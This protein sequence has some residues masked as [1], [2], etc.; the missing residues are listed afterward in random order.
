LR[1][2]KRHWDNLDADKLNAVPGGVNVEEAFTAEE[3]T[4]RLRTEIAFLSALHR[5]ITL[6]FYYE[7]K[8]GAEIAG[9]LNIT[10]STVRWHLSEIKKKLKEGIEMKNLNYEPKKLMVGHDG[11]PGEMNMCGLGKDRLADNIILTCYGKALTVEEIARTLTVAA[12]Y[13]EHHIKDLV[14][15]DYLRV[16]DKNKY[17]TTFFISTQRHHMLA[18]KYKYH[19]IG[20]YAEKISAAF[21]K[22]YDAIKD[23]GFLGC[24]LDR[25]FVLWA[26]M[27]LAI[28]DLYGNALNHLY[29]KNKITDGTPKRKDGSQHW[30]C[31]MLYDDDY[32]KTQ[33]EF[34]TEEVAFRDKANGFGIK[35]RNDGRHASF[36][37]D[38]HATIKAGIGWREFNNP[39]LVELHRI[40]VIIREGLTPDE[41]D[42]PV[43]AKKAEEGYVAMENGRP[44]ML[45][46]FFTHAEFTQLRA[47]LDDIIS[48]LGETLFAPFVEGFAEIF[49]TTLPSTLSKEER[50]YNKF[51]I[52]PHYA[53]LYW[54]ADKNLLRFPTDDEAKR[55]CTAVWCLQ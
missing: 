32:G 10:P 30:V 13:L 51:K 49:E 17:T 7:N 28:N 22:R 6:L 41:F 15:M 18:V 52:T 31:A 21:N 39:D 29:A 11:S 8:R 42:K 23:I 55:L 19:H 5:Q 44:K 46:P 50:N 45:I 34:T 27:P 16:V 14:Y 4:G 35:S 24:D 9:L 37:L 38:S 53:V 48:E 54:L 47:I 26:I 33:T 40:A 43:I 3:L 12:A 36:Q 2:N 1:R 25:N 20:S